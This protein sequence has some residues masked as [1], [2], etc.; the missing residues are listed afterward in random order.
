MLVADLVQETSSSTGT[1]DFTLSSM[2]GRQT[3]NEAFSTGGTNRFP[4]FISHQSAD[5]WEAG[6]GHLSDATTLVRDTVLK[7]SNSNAA[8]S[9]SAG[10]KDIMNDV[11]AQYQSS[12]GQA[13]MM[14]M[15]FGG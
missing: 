5:E 10:I 2:N 13:I 15:V 12:I 1:G 9:F 14:A 3:F 8:V 7:S 4:Y 11:P 6:L